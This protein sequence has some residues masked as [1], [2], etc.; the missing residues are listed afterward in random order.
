MVTNTPK[1]QYNGNDTRFTKA[2][3]GRPDEKLLGKSIPKNHPLRI[4][5]HFP[6]EPGERLRENVREIG[7]RKELEIIF[8]K[9]YI[10]LF[11][12]Y[13]LF[14]GFVAKDFLKYLVRCITS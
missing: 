1:R 6:M 9:L 10:A 8:P 14:F 13:F 4:A 5:K 3:R 11:S 12:F 2:A 7:Q